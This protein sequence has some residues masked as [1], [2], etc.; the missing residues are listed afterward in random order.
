MGHVWFL[1]IVSMC[2]VF[3]ASWIWHV[4]EMN[5]EARYNKAADDVIIAETNPISAYRDVLKEKGKSAAASFL[6]TSSSNIYG[7]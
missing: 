1:V 2:F 5:K 3:G 4:S 7:N 6:A